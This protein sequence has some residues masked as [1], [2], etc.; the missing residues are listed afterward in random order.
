MFLLLVL[1]I[2]LYAQLLLGLGRYTGL[3]TSRQLWDFHL[4]LGVLIVVLAIIGWRAQP[5]VKADTM[6]TLARFAPLVVLLL[7]LA[8]MTGALRGAWVTVLHMLLG[9]VAVGLTDMAYARQRRQL[10]G[11][12]GSSTR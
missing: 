12:G 4:S 7:G 10:A 6:R 5:Q 8:M 9:L 11:S 2:A 1:R 3:I